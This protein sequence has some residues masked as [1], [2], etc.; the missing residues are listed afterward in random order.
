[1]SQLSNKTAAIDRFIENL[2]C[3]SWLIQVKRI[4]IFLLVLVYILS[5]KCRK[6][7]HGPQT[8]INGVEPAASIRLTLAK[9]TL[10]HTTPSKKD[11][12]VAR[13]TPLHDTLLLYAKM[14]A[15]TKRIA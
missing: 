1:M 5:L 3:K 7:Q 13:T 2:N 8:V 14:R 12:G 11:G 10:L 9:R 6:V 15:T 4:L